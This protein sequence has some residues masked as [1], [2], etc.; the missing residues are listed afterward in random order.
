[1]W[2][3]KTVSTVCSSVSFHNKCVSK[4]LFNV[5]S[6]NR[7]AESGRYSQRQ[8][9]YFIAKQVMHVQ[10]AGVCVTFKKLLAQS[11]QLRIIVMAETT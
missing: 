2:S 5:C 7:I 1:M 4:I 3:L 10:S 11:S 9:E 6:G 8:A